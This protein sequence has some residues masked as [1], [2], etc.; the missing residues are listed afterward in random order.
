MSVESKRMNMNIKEAI[1][2]RSSRRTY[3]NQRIEDNKSAKLL[4][5]IRQLNQESGLHLQLYI[6][7]GDAFTG[8]KMSYGM[9][10]NVSNYIALV[11][12]AEDSDLMEKVGYYGE[13]LVLEA[14]MMGLG[15]CWVGGTYDKKSCQCEVNDHEKL[16]G[17]LTLGYT[18]E[19]RPFKERMLYSIVHRKTKTVSELLSADIEAPQWLLHG[20]EAV[21]KAPSAVNKQP[22]RFHYREGMLSAEVSGKLE[23]EL[24]DLG[25]AKLHF[26]IGS[27]YCGQW[28]WGNGGQYIIK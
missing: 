15:T 13:K 19:E 23:Y 1:E 17:I 21:Q 20:M 6:N 12:N 28:K 26:E 16:L 4:D 24:I 11:G 27:D 9:F 14:T 7:N 5:S 18:P 8:I 3:T 22:V 25:I 10:K 2:V